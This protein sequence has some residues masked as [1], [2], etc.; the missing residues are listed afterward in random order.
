VTGNSMTTV[1][2]TN[3]CADNGLTNAN[4][5]QN[6]KRSNATHKP[7]PSCFTFYFAQP[8]PNPPTT[9]TDNDNFCVELLSN[10]QLTEI[11][12]ADI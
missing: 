5:S 7:N 9:Q 1:R 8:H 3:F 12:F 11:N 6:K 10:N 4:A 2:N